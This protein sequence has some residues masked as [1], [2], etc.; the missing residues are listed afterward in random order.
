[1]L[2]EAAFDDRTSSEA[3][4]LWIKLEENVNIDNRLFSIVHYIY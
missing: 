2:W 4:R 1:M 3:R